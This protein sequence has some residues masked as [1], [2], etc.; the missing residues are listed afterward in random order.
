MNLPKV[1]YSAIPSSNMAPN[2]V[3][4]Q[5]YYFSG[6]EDFSG[7][8]ENFSARV[9]SRRLG[10]RKPGPS[11]HRGAGQRPSTY[12]KPPAIRPSTGYC[13]NKICQLSNP[14]G[15]CPGY[16][17]RMSTGLAQGQGTCQRV[18]GGPR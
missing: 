2:P 14:G 5:Q 9:F 3:S 17:C 12:V 13:I 11:G 18:S 6:S 8:Q 1:D 10:P 4:D 7:F 16:G 15:C